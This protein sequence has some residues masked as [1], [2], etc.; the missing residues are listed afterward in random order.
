[1]WRAAFRL[2]SRSLGVLAM[3]GLAIVTITN[4]RVL[5]MSAGESSSNGTER[6]DVAIV[7]GCHVDGLRPAPMLAA[8]LEVALDL[9]RARRVGR[10][11][12]TG[13]VGETAAMRHW[14]AARG[15][16]AGDILV[17]GQ[18]VR[19]LES[20]R[21]AAEAFGIRK[22]VVCTQRL[23]MARSLFLAREA[24]I[25][26]TGVKA[27][28][29]WSDNLRWQSVEALKRTLAFAEVRI[30]HRLDRGATLVASN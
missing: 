25:T 7:P 4:W 15:V 29:D 12:V 21:N 6:Y 22:A 13:N 30:L 23:H 3:V 8:R 5:Q 28:V 26:A 14:L 20:M 1:V 9:Y 10:V 17:D 16:P 2:C 27:D 24:G 11:L 19:T 18:G